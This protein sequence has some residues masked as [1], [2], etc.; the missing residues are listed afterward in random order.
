MGADFVRNRLQISKSAKTSLQRHFSPRKVPL[1][2]LDLQIWPRRGQT[3]LLPLPGRTGPIRSGSYLGPGSDR[4]L[5][6]S[7][8]RSGMPTDQPLRSPQG[9]DRSESGPL[10]DPIRIVY[11]NTGPE[12]RH[13]SPGRVG[14]AA[15]RVRRGETA[16]TRSGMVQDDR[17]RSPLGQGRAK[18]HSDRACMCARPATPA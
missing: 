18:P 5:R 13:R 9:P 6:F 15:A 1:K 4:L 2:I 11:P 8:L 10:P 14:A 16:P 17:L 12:D 3:S 7:R